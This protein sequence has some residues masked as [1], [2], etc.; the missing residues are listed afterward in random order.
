M[1]WG[2]WVE[3]GMRTVRSCIKLAL[4][5]RAAMALTSPEGVLMRQ[6]VMDL[7]DVPAT[8]QLLPKP[9]MC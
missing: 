5:L 6:V 9:P 3:V 1:S 8:A 4:P 7:Q 2:S